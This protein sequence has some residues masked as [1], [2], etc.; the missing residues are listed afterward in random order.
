MKQS[1]KSEEAQARQRAKV[2]IQVQSGKITATEGASRLGI[3]RTAY[4]E[5]EK[6]ALAAMMKSLENGRAGRPSNPAD[7][8]VESLKKAKRDLENKLEVAKQTREVR[9]ILQAWKDK[10]AGT[11][12]KSAS[13]Q[14]AKKKRNRL[15]RERQ[16][17]GRKKRKR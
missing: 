3:S 4:Y 11:S 1:Q 2:I 16:L 12:K 14:A 10:E 5:W 13:E 7:P 9:D 15:K 17:Q 6:K 8:E